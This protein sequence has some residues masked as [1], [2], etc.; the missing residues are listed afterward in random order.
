MSLL[1]LLST[2]GATPGVSSNIALHLVFYGAIQFELL[3]L[4]LPNETG[5]P[6]LIIAEV[7]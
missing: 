7:F 1:L 5:K 4:Q 3:E 6:E 2:F